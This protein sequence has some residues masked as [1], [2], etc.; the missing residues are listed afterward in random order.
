MTRESEI[1]FKGSNL[2]LNE[3]NGGDWIVLE[4]GSQGLCKVEIG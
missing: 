4:L 1:R 3:L 2:S